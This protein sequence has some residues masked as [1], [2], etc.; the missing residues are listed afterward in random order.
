ME[1]LPNLGPREL[2]LHG[3]CLIL[4]RSSKGPAKRGPRA[5]A[6]TWRHVLAHKEDV[7]MKALSTVV[8][9]AVIASLVLAL[10]GSFTA[11]SG[12]PAI[13]KAKEFISLLQKGD[14]QGAYGRLDSNLGFQS[15]PE[16]LQAAWQGLV[17]KAGNFVEFKQSSMEQ[18]SGYFVVT[19]V[20]KFEKGHV[21]I[22]I[23]LDN[24]LRVADM[25]YFNHKAAPAAAGGG[26]APAPAPSPAP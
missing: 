22:K 11:Q 19:Q 3:K 7:G 16:K 2:T 17:A 1:V 9:I 14:Y 21:D 12:D 25:R 18:Q 10:G 20:A 26:P 4:S 6:G 13:S 5:G 15:S 24:M 8:R 23:A